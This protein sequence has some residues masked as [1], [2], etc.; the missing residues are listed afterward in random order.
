M[1]RSRLDT[2]PGRTMPALVQ[3]ML[4][5]G[6]GKVSKRDRPPWIELDIAYREL[7]SELLHML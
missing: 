5:Y 2:V 7:T 6:W 1:P 4:V 3:S